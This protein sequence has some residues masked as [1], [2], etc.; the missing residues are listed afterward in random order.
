MI[1]FYH[2]VWKTISQKWRKRQAAVQNKIN[3]VSIINPFW[4]TYFFLRG[5]NEETSNIIKRCVCQPDPYKN[6]ACQ[7]F[8]RMFSIN[9]PPLGWVVICAISILYQ[10]LEKEVQQNH[11]F[12]ENLKL[13][14][15]TFF[16]HKNMP[17]NSVFPPKLNL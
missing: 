8:R 14:E 9:W 3:K 2:K 6:V 17:R 12:V 13:S 15:N 7:G 5:V 16:D 4:E 1:F 11:F 10:H